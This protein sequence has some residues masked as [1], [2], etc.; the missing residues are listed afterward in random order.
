M[1]D[2]TGSDF[3]KVSGNSFI[4][5]D[6]VYNFIGTNLWYGMHLGSIGPA[7]DRP[8]LAAELDFLHSLGITNLRIMAGSEG[9][10]TEPWRIVPAAQTSP[11]EFNTDLLD[12]LD[13][14]LFEAGKRD[15][16]VI[17]CLTNYWEWTGGLAQYLSWH[18]C[19]PIPYPV[20]CKEWRTFQKYTSCFFTHRESVEC[21]NN[22]ISLL[23]NR[24]NNY[25]NKRYMDD[26]VI[27]SWQLCN[28]GRGYNNE[29]A[30]NKWIEETSGFIKS[31]DSNHLVSAGTE[32]E[33]P[34]TRVGLDFIKNN[35]CSSIDYTTAHLWVQNWNIY[36]P[37]KHHKTFKQSINFAVKYINEHIEKASSLGKPLVLEEFGFPRDNCGYLPDSSTVYRDKFYETVF[38]TVTRETKAGWAAAGV[39]FWAWSGRGKPGETAGSYW[40]PG[41]TL[42]GDP[43]HE[44]QGWYSVYDTDSTVE[45]IRKFSSRFINHSILNH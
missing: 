34:Y 7:G 4:L 28:E 19:G 36:K 29:K 8:R 37:G 35:S 31:M 30:F 13:F 18:G 14:L 41:C 22:Y 1:E 15:M 2:I 5:N 45:I 40:K 20:M 24:V 11:G 16:K 17:L 12:G 26:P 32:G 3:V 27:M 38:D 39:N 25:T 42:L 10:D 21:L 33:T 23:V 44:K 43:P 9:P 6:K